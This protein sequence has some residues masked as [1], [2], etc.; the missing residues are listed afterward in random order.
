VRSKAGWSLLSPE[1]APILHDG[2]IWGPPEIFTT[3]ELA[4]HRR[5]AIL[6]L[7]RFYRAGLQ[8]SQIIELLQK[9][10]WVHAPVNK[11][12]VQ[13]DVQLLSKA[14]KI[15]RRGNSRKWELARRKS[16]DSHDV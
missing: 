11:E 9:C 1:S 3:Q 15:R 5:E 2:Y 14:E 10:A 16:E 6:H 7:L 12:L 13:D 4:V 8:T